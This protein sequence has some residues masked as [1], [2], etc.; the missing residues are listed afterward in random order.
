MIDLHSHSTASD[1]SLAPAD[2]VAFARQCKVEKLALTD[3]DTLS[4]LDEA[5]RAA[6]QIG[7][8][9]VRGVEISALWGRQTVHVVGLGID[10]HN[11]PL[12]QALAGAE[13][14]RRDRARAIGQ[15]L[16]ERAGIEN[17]YS[18][19]CE[20]AGDA[21][22]GRAHY[23]RM[24][25][26]YGYARDNKQVF[27]RYMVRG[28]P[29]Y[30]AANWMAMDGAITLIQQSGGVA[31]LAHPA[32]YALTATKLRGLVGDFAESGGN[33]IEVVSGRPRP[34]EPEHLARLANDHE[35]LAST[36]SDFHGPDKPWLKPGG[37]PALPANCRPL[38][39]VHPLW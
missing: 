11:P 32:R 9:L 38:W 22:I 20:L 29:G 14:T 31:V 3:H 19:T 10:P 24:L 18:R 25:V 13:K 33:A 28:K 23:A 27:K 5:S 7:L 30:V 26:Q 39:E 12:R 21:P 4:G 15:R 16:E 37:S 8:T 36:G 1:G 35:L 17:A 6:N 2:L 34:G